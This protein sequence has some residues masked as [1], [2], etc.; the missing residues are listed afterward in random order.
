MMI[1]HKQ[2]KHFIQLFWIIKAHLRL[3]DLELSSKYLN[4][5]ADGYFFYNEINNELFKFNN[6]FIRNC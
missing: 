3:S 5:Y 1:Y 4:I 2:V 6:Y